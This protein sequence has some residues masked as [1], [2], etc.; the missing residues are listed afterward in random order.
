M[1]RAGTVR[2]FVSGTVSLVVTHGMG[3][4]PDAYNV[5][6]L[7]ANCGRGTPAVLKCYVPQATVLTNNITIGLSTV[8]TSWQVSV[9]VFTIFYNGRLY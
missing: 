7:N 1:L 3:Q 8:V 6:M 5:T 4:I 2:A 9:I